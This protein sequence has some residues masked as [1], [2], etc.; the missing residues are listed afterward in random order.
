MRNLMGDLG[1]GRG[2]LGF[3]GMAVADLGRRVA[4]AVT[5][6][7]DVDAWRSATSWR[8]RMAA[9]AWPRAAALV[10]VVVGPLAGAWIYLQSTRPVAYPPPEPSERALALYARAEKEAHPTPPPGLVEANKS[11]NGGS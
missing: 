8:A 6:T 4:L 1:H 9:V 10:L 3:A 7:I 5:Q 11:W 2:R